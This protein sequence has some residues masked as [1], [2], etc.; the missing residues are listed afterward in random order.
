L[1]FAQQAGELADAR[2]HLF[3]GAV[4]IAQARVELAFSQRQDVGADLE[5][6]FVVGGD[7]FGRFQFQ[8]GAA[9]AFLEGLHPEGFGNM[10]DGF[11]EAV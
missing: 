7:S 11:G 2:V 5:V 4:S 1:F 8:V 10:D 3:D 6:L 9:P